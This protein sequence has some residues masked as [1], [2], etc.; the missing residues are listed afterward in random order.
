MKMNIVLG[1]LT[2][3][4]LLVGCSD[5]AA[6]P[7]AQAEVK[8]VISEESLGLRKTDLYSEDTTVAAKT[9]YRKAAAG[10]SKR[11]ER[12]FDNAPPMIPH[13]TEGMLPITINDNQC[14]GCH[15]PEVAPSVKATPIPKSHFTSFRPNTTIA[16]DGAVVKEGKKVKNTSDFKTV[17]HE[18]G[19]LNQARF[20]CSQCHAPQSQGNL[21][22][23]NN[24]RP[25]FQ[26]EDM[27]HG[28]SLLD[29]INKGVE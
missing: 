14:L 6:A 10:S 5:N 15:M 12:A 13:D 24:F 23:E 7:A 3:A 21:L 1:T 29:T 9:E 19:G 20:N 2:A 4:L 18:L 28:S 26:S 22:V 27:K 16:D 25:D 8:P 17:Q 11:F